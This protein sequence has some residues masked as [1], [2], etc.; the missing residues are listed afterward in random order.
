MCDRVTLIM[1][2][3]RYIPTDAQ[4][5]KKKMAAVPRPR[6]IKITKLDVIETQ[7]LKKKLNK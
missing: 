1:T 6:F 3:V 2:T 5:K 7:S 4:I